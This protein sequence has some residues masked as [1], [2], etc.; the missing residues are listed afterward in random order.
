MKAFLRLTCAALIFMALIFVL[1]T[2]AQPSEFDSA[3]IDSY[4]EEI[5]E[6]Y[7]VTGAN[8]S[9]VQNGEVLY[10]AGYGFRNIETEQA[11]TPETLFSIGSVSKS[12]TALAVAQQ[13]D[14]GNLDLDTPIIDYVPNLTY[15]DPRFEQV[16]LRHLLSHTS[17]LPVMDTLWYAGTVE[18]RDALITEFAMQTFDTEPGATY[19]Y[20]NVAYALAGYV[21]EQVTGETWEDYIRAHIF[22]PLEMTESVVSFDE[23]AQ[24]SNYALPHL[25]NIRE[26]AVPQALFEYIDLIAPAG[27][28]DSNPVN[29]ANYALLQLGDGTFNG[30]RVVSQELLEEMHA[31]TS[32]VTEGYGLG[33]VNTS[34]EGY[35]LVWHNGAIDGFTAAL[36]LV[37]SESLGVT[38]LT[39]SDALEGGDSFVQAGALGIITRILDITPE[40]SAVDYVNAQSGYD[41]EALQTYID[42][43][44]AYQPIPGEF[45]VLVGDYESSFAEISIELRD[46]VPYAVVE[47]QGISLDIE[48]VA[49]EAGSFIGNGRGL[50]NSV[51]TFDVDENGTVRLSQDGSQIAVKAGEGVDLPTYNDPDGHYRLPLDENLTVEQMAD[52]AVFTSSDPEGAFYLGTGETG[53][54]QQASGLD[55]VHRFNPEFE[56]DPVDVQ[57]VPLPSGLTWTQYIYVMEDENLLVVLALSQDGTD[58]FIVLQSDPLTLQSL[59]PILNN[60]LL[61]FALTDE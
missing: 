31:V 1:P 23:M 57:A 50:G 2:Q 13:V 44:R 25:L 3:Q 55:F 43:A 58:Y 5:M 51:F 21:L 60:L 10:T 16:T 42:A 49:I 6:L 56:G 27:A 48:L 52:Y 34:Y 26:G 22:T 37:P 4:L 19:V 33:W 11:V 8:L 45:D 14:A 39:N 9:I 40:E 20:N 54:D 47:Q 61:T 29:M 36:F 17:G 24:T 46:T 53:D 35:D 32:E 12:F 18:S 7:N 28:I 30:E 38:I 15:T 41:P 59:T